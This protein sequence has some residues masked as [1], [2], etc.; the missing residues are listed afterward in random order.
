[1]VR[2]HKL[3]SDSRAVRI[4][5]RWKRG[6]A[7]AFLFSLACIVPSLIASE[8]AEQA[9]AWLGGS[10]WA[11]TIAGALGLIIAGPVVIGNRGI[12]DAVGDL[13]RAPDN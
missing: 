1:M 3:D 6:G 5:E 2:R 11:Q 8:L 4:I 12:L 9:V 10:T 13:A 7:L